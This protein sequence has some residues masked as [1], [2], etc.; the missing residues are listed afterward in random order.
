METIDN[1]GPQLRAQ[2]PVEVLCS[3]RPPS[4]LPRTSPPRGRR[5]VR[6]AEKGNPLFLAAGLPGLRFLG[7]CRL[8][9][10]EA[11]LGQRKDRLDDAVDNGRVIEP[12]WVVLP[13]ETIPRSG[14]PCEREET[15]RIAQSA[16]D[17]RRMRLCSVIKR[18]DAASSRCPGLGR[19][20]VAPA[21]T[22]RVRAVVPT[23]TQRSVFP[24]HESDTAPSEVSAPW[25]G[26]LLLAV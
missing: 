7:F 10:T 13:V 18:C 25:A 26:A 15:D 11:S 24:H 17:P 16:E 5:S 22:R 20:S 9:E 4:P 3:N 14:R 6:T 1:P 12:D 23:N 2:R 21:V 19:S 8:A